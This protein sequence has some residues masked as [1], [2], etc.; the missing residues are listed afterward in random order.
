MSMSPIIRAAELPDRVRELDGLIEG[1]LD[2][3]QAVRPVPNPAFDIAE[4]HSEREGKG[5][6]MAER[7]P[8]QDDPADPALP[9]QIDHIELTGANHSRRWDF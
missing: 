2:R 5:A 4:Y 1:F 6:L 7:R 3:T 9:V 8:G